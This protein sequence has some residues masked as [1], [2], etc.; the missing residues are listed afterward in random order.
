MK[1]TIRR[2][3][4]SIER[5]EMALAKLCLLTMIVVVGMQVLFRYA[6]NHP[7]TWPEE[8]S[9]F[10]LIWMTFLVADILVKRK[11]H[12]EVEFFA[13]KLSPRGQVIAA[14]IVN[15]YI[16]VFLVFLIFSSIRLETVQIHHGVGAALR[17]PK[18][19]Y[20][21]A[22]TVCGASMLLSFLF[23]EW[24]GLQRLRALKG[25]EGGK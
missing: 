4:K 6:F 25:E 5:V 10:L 8:L 18:A 9:G 16:I 3:L 14:L 20:T 23:M 17:I 15:L 11:G 2:V 21:M 12:V 24:E 22:A 7:L 19:F 1:E 13:E